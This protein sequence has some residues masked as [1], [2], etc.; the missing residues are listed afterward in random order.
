MGMLGLSLRIK[1]CFPVHG[2]VTSIIWKGGFSDFIWDDLRCVSMLVVWRLI[3]VQNNIKKRW[4]IFPPLF[5]FVRI[6][7]NVN[8][9]S[10]RKKKKN[11]PPWPRI[12]GCD[13]VRVAPWSNFRT[14]KI[15]RKKKIANFSGRKI[16]ATRKFFRQ[17]K[18]KKERLLKEKERKKKKST[19]RHRASTISALLFSIS[20]NGGIPLWRVMS[21]SVT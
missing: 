3:S 13:T 6:D 14:K 5:F 2:N 4:I 20:R 8:K 19:P 9:Q 12:V 18:W 17:A 1:F 7:P 11:S 21:V 16:F 15:I 10:Q